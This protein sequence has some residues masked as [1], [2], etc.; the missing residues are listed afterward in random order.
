PKHELASFV[1]EVCFPG[2]AGG[3]DMQEAVPYNSVWHQSGL[4]GNKSNQGGLVFD[5]GLG[6]FF[7]D[8]GAHKPGEGFGCSSPI[9]VDI[10]LRVIALGQVSE[11]MNPAISSFNFRER[12]RANQ[13]HVLP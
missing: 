8:S 6:V 12:E 7:G 9:G 5:V 3:R 10:F 1:Y 13:I 4:E 11:A 2:T